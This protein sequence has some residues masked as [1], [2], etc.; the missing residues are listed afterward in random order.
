MPVIMTTQVIDDTDNAR[1]EEKIRR[2]IHISPNTSAEKI[3]E[4]NRLTAFRL[5]LSKNRIR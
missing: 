5:W 4:A 2:F 1:F 3:K